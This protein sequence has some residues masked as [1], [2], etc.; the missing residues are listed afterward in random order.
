MHA[1]TCI[2]DEKKPASK[3]HLEQ[4]LPESAE[5]ETETN[6]DFTTAYRH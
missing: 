1:G 6:F 4:G 2:C 5:R 3:Q